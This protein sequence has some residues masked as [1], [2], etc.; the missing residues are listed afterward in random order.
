MVK[1]VFGIGYGVLGVVASLTLFC[2]LR[3]SAQYNRGLF[4][5]SPEENGK[6]ALENGADTSIG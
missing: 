1:L 3:I 4:L 5:S 2:S 6:E